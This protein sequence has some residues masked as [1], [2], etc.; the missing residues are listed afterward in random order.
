MAWSCAAIAAAA[1]ALSCVACA[2]PAASGAAAPSAG[3][4]ND[5]P[6]LPSGDPPSLLEIAEAL[7]RGLP[8]ADR[9]VATRLLVDELLARDLR[10]LPRDPLAQPSAGAIVRAAY[11]TLVRTLAPLPPEQRL[12]RLITLACM[13]R[14]D[15]VTRRATGLAVARYVAD[16]GRPRTILVTGYLDEASVYLVLPPDELAAEAA[17]VEHD[18]TAYEL[19]ARGDATCY[20]QQR[21]LLA[22]GRHAIDAARTGS[23]DPAAG[24]FYVFLRNAGERPQHFAPP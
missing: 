24:A 2:A 17:G 19:E 6:P 8:A 14:G 1:F 18:L 3:T 10:D 12:A 15:R 21:P 5:F 11:G 13:R 7:A 20:A 16:R 9:A 4:R 23:F 22:D